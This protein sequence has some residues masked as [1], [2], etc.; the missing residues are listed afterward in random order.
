[1]KTKIV[2]A[3]VSDE[4]DVY[5][6]QV[7][8]SAFS[9]RQ[10]NPEAF[11]ELVVDNNTDTTIK[12]N[13]ERLLQYIDKKT[14]V[15]VPSQY[16]KVQTSR[17]L[18]TSLRHNV[19]G[20]FLFIDSDTIVTDSLEEADSLTGNIMMVLDYHV[21]LEQ[22]Y[23]AK[24]VKRRMKSTGVAFDSTMPYY[25]SG[26]MYVRENEV[27]RQLFQ[28]WH[29]KWKSNVETTGL[30]LDQIPLAYA[31][32]ATSQPISEL[33]GYWNCQIMNNGLPFLQ[34][35]KIIHY[36]MSFAGIRNAK[37]YLFHDRQ[38]LL[39]IKEQGA[40]PSYIADMVAHAKETFART[41]QIAA[42]DEISLL[43]NSLY[44]LY[45]YHPRLYSW[46]NTLAA[47]ILKLTQP[48]KK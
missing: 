29:E 5:L 15:D 38:L 45:I 35:A 33:E 22:R 28:V 40:I 18:K 43:N 3:V 25:N 42:G 8:L 37:P 30:H 16:N 47:Q 31:N 19:E 1:M 6:E 27:S 24:S 13:R 9:L 14:V 10:H 34:R 41:N 39:D 26:I 2:Y 12:G 48:K 7:A 17:Y 32:M 36:F 44:K 21:S 11:V 4:K 46:F 23:N 20:D